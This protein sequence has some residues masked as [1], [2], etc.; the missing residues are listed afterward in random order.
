MR[1]LGTPISKATF[2]MS[3]S[4]EGPRSGNELSSP[5]GNG[6]PRMSLQESDLARMK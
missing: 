1:T 3:G 4:F 2:V 6:G 5:S